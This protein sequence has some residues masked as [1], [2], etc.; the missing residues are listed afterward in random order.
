[1]SCGRKEFGSKNEAIRALEQSKTRVT[2]MM[3]HARNASLNQ[4]RKSVGKTVKEDHI[5]ASMPRIRISA[6]KK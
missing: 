6:A 2:E 3:A 5:I 4:F 1:M